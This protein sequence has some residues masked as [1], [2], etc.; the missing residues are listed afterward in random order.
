MNI[1]SLLVLVRPW[2]RS[3]RLNGKLTGMS[4]VSTFDL[5]A[6]NLAHI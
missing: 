6:V 3:S 5:S 2:A 1:P 4:Y